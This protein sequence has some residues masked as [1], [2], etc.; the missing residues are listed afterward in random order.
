MHGYVC[1]FF[2]YVG[3]CMNIGVN[4]RENLCFG[5]RMVQ[6]LLVFFCLIR[7]LDELFNIWLRLPFER[8]RENAR[9]FLF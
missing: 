7:F 3:K 4:C 6:M 8:Q 1:R 2:L 5:S 9:P